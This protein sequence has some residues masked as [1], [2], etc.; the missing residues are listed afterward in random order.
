MALSL[1]PCPPS[2][3]TIQ[4]FLKLA[5]EHDTR[6][7]VIS[8]WSRLTA[9]QTGLTLDKSSNEALAVLLPL[10]DWLEKEKLDKQANEA[11]THEVV[12]SAHVENYAMKLFL[13]ADK[14][15]RAA[16]FGK[17]VVKCFYSAGILFDVMQT[18]GPL[19]PEV[20]HYRKYAKMK[21]AYI[22]NCLKN[23]ETPIAGP[24]AEDDDNEDDDNED[25][26]EPLEKHQENIPSVP[27]NPPSAPIQ[28][29]APDMSSLA[30]SDTS[31]SSSVGLSYDKIAR[32]QKL[33]KYAISALDYQDTNTA[34]ENLT[35][36][37]HL[38]KTGQELE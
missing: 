32:A 16:N 11:I 5:T 30:I 29:P 20:A 25:G 8:Y 28:T 15:D 36:A 34:V 3:K 13:V 19:T 24:L 4:H 23:G 12:A 21:A 27:Y 1:P 10:M 31:A 35:K 22:H 6:D 2:L 18:F 9:L 37:L 38:V 7:P 14:Q 17:N 33:C 26:E